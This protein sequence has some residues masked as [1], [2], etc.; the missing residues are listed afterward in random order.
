MLSATFDFREF[1]AH[2]APVV[3][4]AARLTTAREIAETYGIPDDVASIVA[5]FIVGA[6]GGE[7]A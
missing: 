3:S 4:D 6:V 7:P 1:A 5:T 2:M